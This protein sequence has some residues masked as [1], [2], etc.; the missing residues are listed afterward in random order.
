MILQ[1]R[2][3]LCGL[4]LSLLGL[5]LAS[6]QTPPPS[7]LQLVAVRSAKVL[8]GMKEPISG[9]VTVKNTGKDPQTV[10]VRAWLECELGQAT[11]SQ[12]VQVIVA[13]EK[14]ADAA[15]TW[16]KAMAKYGHALKAEV[17]L[18]GQVFAKGEDYFNACDQYW[19]VALPMGISCMWEALDEKTM[20][21][22][23][24]MSW[25]NY[26]IDEMRRGYYN[27]FEHFFWAEDDFLG[28][29]PQKEVWWSGQARYRETNEG[30]K[31]FIAR[32]HANGIK[33]ITYAKLTG[34]GTY[35]A[36][37][38]RQNP[39][40]VWQTNG[41]LSV[42]RS[43]ASLAKWDVPTLRGDALSSGWNAVNWNMNDPKVVDIGIKALS[44][45][46]TMFGWDGA[47]WD[48][49]F[50][51]QTEVTDLDGK[52]VEKLTRDQVD[53]R[54]AANMRRTKD[55]ITKAHPDYFYGYNWMMGTW[56]QSMAN[57]PRESQE[58]LHNGGL[59]MNEFIRGAAGVMH[60]QHKWEAYAAALVDDVEAVKQL[61]GYYGPIL[62]APDNPD[63]K[64]SNIFAY[65]AG[66]HPYY[67]HK[68]GG[69]VTRY[70][71]F[72]WDTALTRLHEP[73]NTVVAPDSVWWRQWVFQRSI[74]KKHR[75]LII[76]LINPPTKPNVGDNKQAED[77][78]LPLKDI[79]VRL[80]P[81]MLNGWTPVRATNLSPEPLVADTVPVQTMEGIYKVTVPSVAL[82]H[83]LVIDLEQKGGR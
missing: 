35:G 10:Q 82:W 46:A 23:T 8:Y 45:S 68:W 81:T 16:P 43:A 2:I 73:E 70:S 49:N 83:I 61:G 18:N 29:T 7:P 44:D 65:A 32:S 53:A 42:D 74:D 47:R 15:F 58:L 27:S 31:Q 14:T 34:G 33:A 66:A 38:A 12:Q 72:I 57:N 60:P 21:P 78:S 50:D 64:Y 17:S 6:A 40:W 63:G 76:H 19:N 39:E 30:L 52:S 25:M 28:L 20:M 22:K 75:Q 69:F 36:E 26:R 62:D 24:D 48:G 55:A 71:A 67:S 11:K 51:V 80:F 41:V 3:I 9:T 37:I 79:E 4:A 13:P 59:V 77:A 56:K 54:N 1:L 5:S